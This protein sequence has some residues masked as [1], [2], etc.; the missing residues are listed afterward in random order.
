[1]LLH[2]K[3]TNLRI[4]RGVNTTHMNMNNEPIMIENVDL[5]HVKQVMLKTN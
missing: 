1:M 4:K 5:L 2:C 3:F